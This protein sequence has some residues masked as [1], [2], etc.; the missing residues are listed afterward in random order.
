MLGRQCHGLLVAGTIWPM[1]LM[2]LRLLLIRLL[3][4]LM[5]KV[6]TLVLRMQTT[7]LLMQRRRRILLVMGSVLF[8]CVVVFERLVERSLASCRILRMLRVL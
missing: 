1:A 7:L 6:R 2:R 5:L 3:I 8:G 4:R